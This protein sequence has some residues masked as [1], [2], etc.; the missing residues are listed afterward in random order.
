MVSVSFHSILPNIWKA[1]KTS[2]S[3]SSQLERPRAFYILIDFLYVNNMGEKD[4]LV[5]VSIVQQR[6]I[7]SSN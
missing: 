1:P 7:H 2:Q 3:W 6:S 4:P 5:L